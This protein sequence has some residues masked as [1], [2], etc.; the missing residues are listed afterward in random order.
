LN[1]ETNA[2]DVILCRNVL[3]YF[4]PEIAQRVV[5]N[6]RRC[7]VDDGSLLVGPA[8]TSTVLFKSFHSLQFEGVTVY[9]KRPSIGKWEQRPEETAVDLCLPAAPEAPVPWNWDDSPASPQIPPEQDKR[10]DPRELYRRGDYG[11]AV[12]SILARLPETEIESPLLILLVRALA[13]L[14]R[15]SEAVDWC[16]KAVNGDKLNPETQYL[17]ATV[18]QELGQL[19][20]A[21]A[22]LKRALYL[23]PG[24]IVAHFALGMLARRCGAAG[25]AERHFANARALLAGL[26]PDILL[27]ESEGMTAGRLGEVIDAMTFRAIPREDGRDSGPAHGNRLA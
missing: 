23:D 2:M 3:M 19:D 7:L 14:G 1:G 6:L 22:S 21:A 17:L 27:P 12:A 25:D 5:D 10:V 4:G 18:Q 11:P 20:E 9:R 16:N 13:N 26:D 8:E 15:L 24:M